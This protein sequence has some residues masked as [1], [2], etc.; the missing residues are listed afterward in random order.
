MFISVLQFLNAG[1]SENYNQSENLTSFSFSSSSLVAARSSNVGP[2]NK[3]LELGMSGMS[4]MPSFGGSDIMSPIDDSG[5]GSHHDH[6]RVV[7]SGDSVQSQRSSNASPLPNGFSSGQAPSKGISRPPGLGISIPSPLGKPGHFYNS[8]A[9]TA[10]NLTLTP[11]SSSDGGSDLY[12]IGRQSSPFHGDGP[13]MSSDYSRRGK[14]ESELPP[15]ISNLGGSFDKEDGEHDGLLGLQALRDRAHT[16]PGPINVAAYSSSPL[17]RGIIPDQHR[18]R[19]VSRD[20]GRVQGARPP[21]SGLS[22]HATEH[23]SFQGDR[24]VGGVGMPLSNSRS[25]DPSPPPNYSQESIALPGVISRPGF[26][27][28]AGDFDPSHRRSIST[29]TGREYVHNSYGNNQVDRGQHSIDQLSHKFGQLPSLNSH[30]NHQRMHIQQSLPPGQHPLPPGQPYGQQSLPRHQRSVSQPG[31]MRVSSVQVDHYH[32]EVQHS[33]GSDY[34]VGMASNRLPPG[35]DN[36][37]SDMRYN[38]HNSQQ[39]HGHHARSGNDQYGQ[40]RSN[41]MQHGSAGYDGG[42]AV[43]TQRRSSLHALPSTGSGYYGQ[44]MQ[45][46]ESLDFV[47]GHYRYPEGVPVVASNEEMRIFTNS[48]NERGGGNNYPHQR[49]ERLV[50]PA[51]SPLHPIYGGHHSRHP[52][53]AGSSAMSSSPMSMGSSGVVSAYFCPKMNQTRMESDTTY[54]WNVEQRAGYGQTHDMYG[55]GSRG[56][57]HRVTASDDDLSHPLLGENIEVPADDHHYMINEGGPLHSHMRSNMG[58]G[59]SGS[60]DQQLPHYGGM[61]AVHHL[62]TAG[63]ALPMP[64]VMYNVKFK[65]TQR[66]FVIGPRLNRDLKVG[67][68]VKVEADRGED[69]GIVV[70]KVPSEKYNLPGRSGFR[71]GMGEM[72]IMPPQTGLGASGAPDLKRII[73]LA[74]HDEVSL[75]QMKR[76]EEEELLKIC[77]TKVRQRGLPMT[78]VDAEYQFDRHKLTFFFEAEG[79]IDFRELVRD[80]FSIYKTRIWMQQLDKNSSPACP[81]AQLQQ[82]LVMDYGTPIM[83]PESEYS[84]FSALSGAPGDNNTD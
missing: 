84:E 18:P 57:P 2:R 81:A 12:S 49:H 83:A 27:P 19:A 1:K 20:G 61:E 54:D 32:D 52:S 53:D 68:Y 8:S 71:G 6:R 76:E 60:V 78:V 82:P 38:S 67:T 5:S 70:G 72:G 50:S 22:P 43:H 46:R 44:N 62:P 24:G 11:T 48:D 56:V 63:S 28:Y 39:Q 80:L 36:D 41:S 21:R 42:P 13:S 14:D 23:K 25:R 51:H 77:R 69:L 7:D 33:R 73:R 30:V 55:G 34:G 64:K 29:D 58:H 17:V 26:N 37:Y 66:N 75:L 3:G 15:G 4:L 35:M 31:P 9:S 16:S 65:R 10:Q 40:G 47:P 59:R 45:R 79:R 74:T